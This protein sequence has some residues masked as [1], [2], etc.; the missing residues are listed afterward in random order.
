MYPAWLD[1]Y[2][3]A[4]ICRLLVDNSLVFVLIEL[5]LNT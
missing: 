3:T 2:V 1:P 4:R 5:E